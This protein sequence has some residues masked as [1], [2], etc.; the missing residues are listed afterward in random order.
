MQM[1]GREELAGILYTG[2]TTGRSKGVML[3]HAN[4]VSNALHMLSEAC[5]RRTPCISTPRQCFISPMG[6]DVLLAD[7]RRH[8]CDRADFHPEVVMPIIE[9]EKVTATLIVPTMTQMLS[10]HPTFKTADLSSPQ[11]H[12]VGASPISEPLLNRAMAGLPGKAFHQL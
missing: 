5:C 2:S 12:H 7:R 6:R 3:S 1:S 4:I 10:D 8:Q 9:K 11:A